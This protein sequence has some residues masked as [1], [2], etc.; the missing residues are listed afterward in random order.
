MSITGQG[1]VH[2]AE[3]LNCHGCSLID[4]TKALSGSSSVVGDEPLASLSSLLGLVSALYESCPKS[5]LVVSMHYLYRKNHF[6]L[7]NNYSCFIIN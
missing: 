7:F 4:W 3:P 2:L 5:T 1:Q 6:I